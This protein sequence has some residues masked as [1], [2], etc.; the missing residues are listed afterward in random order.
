ME[1]EVET[2]PPWS[3]ELFLADLKRIGETSVDDALDLTNQ[4]FDYFLLRGEA[5]VAEIQK[6]CDLLNPEDHDPSVL[7]TALIAAWNGQRV[8]LVYLPFL[9]KIEKHFADN[10]ICEKEGF[11]AE[12]QFKNIRG[13][14]SG[15]TIG[16]VA[17]AYG[18]NL[19]L[20]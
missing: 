1:P 2:R 3:P 10:K 13:M 19:H 8:G 12:Y 16:D 14:T 9:A 18:G 7:W 5:G 20:F 17:R 11:T 6:V 15:P 4:V